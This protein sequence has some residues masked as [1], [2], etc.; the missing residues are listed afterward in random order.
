[1][2][3]KSAL[4][5]KEAFKEKFIL[6]LQQRR[7]YPRGAVFW[8]PNKRQEAEHLYDAVQRLDIEQKLKKISDKEVA[9]AKKLVRENERREVREAAAEVRRKEKAEERVQIDARK[10]EA[11][12]LKEQRKAAIALKLPEKGKRKASQAPQ[13]RRC[14]KRVKIGDVNG[15]PHPVPPQSPPHRITT[16]GRNVKLPAKFK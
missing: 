2:G 12:R 7:E 4:K 13:A 3:L 10:A 1:M 6:S 8:S 15:A 9:A 14:S 16:R 5:Q 11:A